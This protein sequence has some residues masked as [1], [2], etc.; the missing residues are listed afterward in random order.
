MWRV[1]TSSCAG[2]NDATA[3]VPSEP[4]TSGFAARLKPPPDWGRISAASI[5]KRHGQRGLPQHHYD[6]DGHYYGPNAQATW[7]EAKPFLVVLERLRSDAARLVWPRPTV[8]HS[9]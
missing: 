1:R 4:H 5:S 2:L 3:R 9:V 6:R 7:Q 8:A